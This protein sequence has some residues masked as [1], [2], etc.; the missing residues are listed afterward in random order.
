MTKAALHAK[1]GNAC[2]ARGDLELAGDSYKAALRIAPN[3]I[4]VLVQSRQCADAVRPRA[5]CDPALPPGHQARPLALDVAH[6]SGAGADGDRADVVAKAVLIELA[7][8]RPQDAPVQHQL[9]KPCF[10]LNELDAALELSARRS[11]SIRAT[12]RACTGSAASGN[13]RATLRRP[14]RPM[15]RRRRSSL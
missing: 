15:P 4:G 12:P 2:M 8:E 13:S 14:S 6:Q 9:G 1:L 7:E 10:E 5:G 3:M 11:R